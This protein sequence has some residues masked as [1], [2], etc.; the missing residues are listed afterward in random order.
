M[1]RAPTPEEA[2]AAMASGGGEWRTI[3]GR[4]AAVPIQGAIHSGSDKPNPL[5]VRN[6]NLKE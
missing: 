4:G 5:L 3:S 1:N 6:L 2:T